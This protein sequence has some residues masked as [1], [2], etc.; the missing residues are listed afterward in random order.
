MA[1]TMKQ[2]RQAG[3]LM[4]KI[5]HVSGRIFERMLKDYDIEINS[6]QGRIMFALWQQDHISINE[7]TKKTQL[8]KSTLTSMLDRL[9][10][11]RYVKRQRSKEDRRVI[12]IERT[13]KDKHLENKYVE[14]SQELIKLF[15]RGFS[16][17]QI[18]RFEKNLEQILDNL[19]RVEANFDSMKGDEKRDQ[20]G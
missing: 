15:Y 11:M 9:E 8:K 14:L 1:K 13:D 19:M 16:E 18:N 7:L 20:N 3:F 6:A 10:T 4:A 2:Q 17:R 12:L 5:R